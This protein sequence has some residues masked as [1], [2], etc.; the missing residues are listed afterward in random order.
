[1]IVSQKQLHKIINP[2]QMSKKIAKIE[3]NLAQIK[4]TSNNTLAEL[5]ETL[6]SLL[7]MKSSFLIHDEQKIKDIIQETFSVLLKKG[8]HGFDNFEAIKKYVCKISYQLCLDHLKEIKK[9]HL[10]EIDEEYENYRTEILDAAINEFSKLP[11]HKKEIIK[12][13]IQQGQNW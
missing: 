10:E 7:Y 3:T 11:P 8:L 9:E 5:F 1:M 2:L 13:R 6:Y 12:Q 4:A